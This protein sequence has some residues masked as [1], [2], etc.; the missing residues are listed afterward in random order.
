M[1]VEG[2]G[3]RT[4]SPVPIPAAAA[5]ALVAQAPP[6]GKTSFGRGVEVSIVRPSI[7]FSEAR[8]VDEA[9]YVLYYPLQSDE[10]QVA[11]L[12]RGVLHPIA[13]A[14]PYVA[15]KFENENRVIAAKALDGTWDWY[16]L[17]RG[18]ATQISR[19]VNTYYGLPHHVL[20]DGDT[21]ADGMAGTGSALDDIRAHHRVSV[22]SS[23]AI[24]R[25]TR[26]ALA[27][28]VGAYC[29]HFDGKNYAAMDNPG[30][31]FRL[32]GPTATLV[33]AGWI[34]AASD[35]YLLLESS[36]ELIEAEVP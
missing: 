11:V 34:E 20:S 13:L 14:R 1:A 23:A 2:C 22:L 29:D 31:I 32:D 24:D 7:L 28:I 3:Q 12:S 4:S 26:G 27:R 10:Q 17:R 5:A 15:M 8:V 30:I 18:R 16:A 33:A 21:C 35:R 6:I 36:D 9:L 25:A 19:P